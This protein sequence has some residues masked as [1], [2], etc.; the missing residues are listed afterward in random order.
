MKLLYA[1]CLSD[2][3][4]KKSASPMTIGEFVR[5]K[6]SFLIFSAACLSALPSLAQFN[7]SDGS[8]HQPLVCLVPFSVAGYTPAGNG[9]QIEQAAAQGLLPVNGA[10]AAQ[11]SQVR[12][13][14]GASGTINLLAKD[15]PQG[16]AFDDLGP[17]L[18]ERPE[19]IG[20]NHV[21]GAFTYQR[22]NFNAVDGLDL[23]N[24]QLGY[25]VSQGPSTY[26]GTNQVNVKFRL[27]QYVALLSYGV[28]KTTDLSIV[29]PFNA[30]TASAMPSNAQAFT[31]TS[32][33]NA[34]GT[35]N[36]TQS[37]DSGSASGIGDI[38][39]G[40]K[41]QVYGGEG[42]AVAASAGIGFRIPTGDPLNFLGS[43]AYGFELYGL[44]SY[45]ASNSFLS[46]HLKIGKQWN[47]PTELL[48]PTGQTSNPLPGGMQYEVGTDINAKIR[49]KRV[50][51]S[52]DV[53]GS[54]F[55]DGPSLRLNTV[56][57]SPAPA[58]NTGVPLS[59]TFA[60]SVNDTYTTISL[61]SGLK[62]NPVEELL[63][64]GNVL[65]QLNNVGLRS[66]PV[67]LAGIAYNFKLGKSKAR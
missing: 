57:L 2:R 67:P 42:K 8:S 27:D 49:R 44:V 20:K 60:Q 4:F 50:T 43:G 32:T 25:S 53:I 47:G 12:V 21:Y 48:N 63:I 26:Y 3:R 22:F 54:Q 62:F 45:R 51:L 5:R 64:Y 34:Y 52:V 16:V 46:P 19:T 55:V 10:I 59:L 28:T 23:R 30:I 36:V 38:K 65:V 40:V 14:S 35:S 13:P 33:S 39:F 56:T 61:S 31:Y 1:S 6:Y 37:A 15:N 29:V 11:L 7:C 9:S 17:V 58:A 66:D 18:T 41:Q 24:L